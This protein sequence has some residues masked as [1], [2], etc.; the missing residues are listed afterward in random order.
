M[1]EAGRPTPSTIRVWDPGVR[2]FHW[3]LAGSI[4]LAF[5]SSEEDSALSVWHIPAGWVAAVLIAFRLVWGFVGG[6]HARFAAFIRP[7]ALGE[8]VRSLLAGRVGP[9]LGHNPLGALAVIGLLVLTAATVATGAGGGEDGHEA[10]AYGLLGLVAAHVAAV[11]AMS[12]LT[13]DNLVRAMVTGRKSAALFPGAGDARPP[14]GIALPLAALVVGAAA[15]GV[16]RLDPAGFTPVARGEA[17]EAG[18]A[19]EGAEADDEG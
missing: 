10:V 7:A 15:M 6:E 13:R 2:L 4:A 11:V 17:G 1:S 9:S 8:H 16:V 18:E 3:L 12:F 14:A 5:L 19:G